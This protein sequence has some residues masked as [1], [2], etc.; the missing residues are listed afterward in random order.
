ML[1]QDDLPDDLTRHFAQ[2][3]WLAADTETTGLNPR[4]DRLCVVQ[5]YDGNGTYAAVQLNR[6]NPRAAVN[7]VSLL[8]VQPPAKV[9]PKLIFHHA[10]FDMGF[11]M[12][13][14]GLTFYPGF[15]Y[16]TRLGNKIARTAAPKHSLANVVEDLCGVKLNKNEQTSDWG[17]ETLTAVQQEYMKSDVLYLHS[18]KE[19]QEGIAARE[20]RAEL[21]AALQ[22]P[23]PSL[24][25]AQVTEFGLEVYGY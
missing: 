3:E 24:A 23:L 12:A 22:L 14:L 19:Q 4:R 15:V 6:Q 8:Q 17:A 13:H 9:Q 11:L 18:I 16:C 21:L 5:L 7:L 25:L 1:Y 10:L 20:G 2:Q